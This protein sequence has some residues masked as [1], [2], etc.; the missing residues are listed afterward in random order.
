MYWYEVILQNKELLKI[1]YALVI[2][3]ACAV[4]VLKTDRLF[5][6]SSHQGIRYFRNA[7]FFYGLAFI[8]RYFLVD[9]FIYA[10]LSM[11]DIFLNLTKDIFEF[12]LVMA[13]F[14]L[15]YSLVWKLFE[16]PKEHHFSSLLHSKIA[17]F[18]LMAFVI[19]LLDHLWATY[20]F[21]FFSQVILF[22]CAV[23]VSFINYKT[24]RSQHKFR[25]F[26]CIAMILSLAIWTLN[27]VAASFSNWHL[28]VLVNVYT[29]NAISFLLFLFGVVWVTK[30][31]RQN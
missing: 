7:F 24:G 14:F 18:Y 27:L 16:R 4:I 12:L 6:L 10:N 1:F 17:I 31:F 21:M 13:G 3:L 29:L 20:Y 26:Y 23:A 22:A 9:V 15:L 25:K 5:R 8:A 19:I 2:G 11:N 28:G 30:K